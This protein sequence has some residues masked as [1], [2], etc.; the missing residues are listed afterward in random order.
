MPRPASI[1]NKKGKKQKAVQ[2]NIE[3]IVNGSSPLYGAFTA[4]TF[5]LTVVAIA[6]Q[7]LELTG[8]FGYGPTLFF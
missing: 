6:M 2:E 7:Y 8:T 3:Y 4:L 1:K 5:L